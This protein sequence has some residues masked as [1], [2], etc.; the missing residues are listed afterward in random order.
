MPITTGQMAEYLI[1]KMKKEITTNIASVIKKGEWTYVFDEESQSTDYTDTTILEA[2]GAARVVEEGAGAP[3]IKMNQGWNK[4]RALTEYGCKVGFTRRLRNMAD[5]KAIKRLKDGL[6]LS[7][8]QLL[9]NIGMG[10]LEYG[11]TAIA[12]V[13][14]FG[15]KPMI[16]S[17][18]ADG[19]TIFHTTHTFA[20]DSSN[21]YSNKTSAFASLAQTSLFNAIY[22]VQ[23]WR[24]NV[25]NALEADPEGLLIPV[26]LGEKAYELLHSR[27]KSETANRAD[28]ALND[29][30]SWESCKILRMIVNQ[31]EW[32]IRTNL[33]NDY[34]FGSGWKPGVEDKYDPNTGIF[35]LIMS[36]AFSHGVA[37][38]RKIYANKAA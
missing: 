23:L 18:S 5:A 6:M 16:D 2:M 30:M 31:T 3:E 38:P 9:N 8:R 20:S 22:A 17:L 24:N 4:R 26:S 33:P 15:G 25:G 27:T 29:Y 34:I 37:D 35:E 1:P 36:F 14:T 11:D 10:Y 32:F 28:N 13:P 21:T 7:P 12:S 19:L